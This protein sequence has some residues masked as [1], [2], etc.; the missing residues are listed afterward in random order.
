MR[1]SLAKHQTK[2][3]LNDDEVFI[4]YAKAYNEKVAFAISWAELAK[5]N[6]REYDIFIN[7]GNKLY[8]GKK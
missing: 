7:V 1:S 2:S 4:E 8:L 3:T 6:N 5:L